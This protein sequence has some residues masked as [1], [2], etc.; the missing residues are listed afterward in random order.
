MLGCGPSDEACGLCL[1]VAVRAGKGHSGGCTW[2]NERAFYLTPVSNHP[3]FRMG[4]EG[5]LLQRVRIVRNV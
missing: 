4:W 3:E 5:R 2:M 1:W